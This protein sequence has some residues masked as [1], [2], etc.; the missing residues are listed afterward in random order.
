MKNSDS[1]IYSVSDVNRYIKEVLET[2]FVG[3]IMVEGEISQLQKSQLGLYF[4]FL[5]AMARRRE[6][7]F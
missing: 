5:L 7:V 4:F 1:E 6:P 3:Y 2:S